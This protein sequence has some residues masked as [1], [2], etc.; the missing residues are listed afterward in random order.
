MNKQMTVYQSTSFARKVKI[1][2]PAEKSDLDDVVRALINNPLIGVEKKGDLKGI[3]IHKFKMNKHDYLLSYR[4]CNEK[5]LELIMI[6]PH[7]NYY[8]ALK[9]YLG[10]RH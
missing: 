9:T 10:S 5:N 2:S 7:E 6:G 3:F 1:M 8:H 4:I